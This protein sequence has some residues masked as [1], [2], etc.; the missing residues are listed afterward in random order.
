M[1]E[2]EV[3][4]DGEQVR[5][6][7]AAQFPQW[8]RMPVSAV[9]PSGTDHALY[10]IG[11]ELV[12]RLPR[13]DWALGQVET[14]RR[15]LP[16]LAPHLPLRIPAPVGTGQP[17]EG[18]PWAWSVVPWLPGENPTDANLDLEAAAADLAA[19]LLALRAI[20]TEGGP[21]KGGL[22]RGVPLANRDELTRSAIAELGDR[23]DTSRVTAAWEEALAAHEWP[24]RP[25]WIHGDLLP[26]NVLVH[27]RRLSA[28]IDFGALGLGDP[29]A[30]VVPAW[31][32]FDRQTR[33][34]FRA[35]L[36]CDEDTW[37]RGRGWALSTAL[38][39]LPYY[40]DTAPHI[41]AENQRRIAAVLEG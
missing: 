8:A 7:V 18:Y 10:R 29:A 13:I 20:D 38:V 4:T 3:R 28:V 5:R 14:D 30:D 22:D 37:Q 21:V 11:D 25:R 15:W 40:W 26:G 9:P 36:A 1:H 27:E 23:V 19:F 41:V 34:V 35:A 2:N 12:A 33:R 17:G 32:L 16:V 39:S 6:L 24:G 31:T